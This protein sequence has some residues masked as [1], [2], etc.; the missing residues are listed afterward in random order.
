MSEPIPSPPSYPIIGHAGTGVYDPVAS[1]KSRR[2]LREKYGSIY[3]LNFFGREIIFCSSQE[4]VNEL[5]DESR[6][7]KEVAGGPLEE[8]RNGIHDGLF[9]A[10]GTEE[11]WGIAHRVLLPGFGPA[12]IQGMFLAMLDINAQLLL[13]WE[14]F[15]PDHVITPTEDFTRL[16]FDTIALSM[17]SHRFNSFYMEEM[18]PFCQ[19]MTRFLIESG[20]RNQ[21][22]SM[23][24]NL[25]RAENAQYEADIK[26]MAD[27]CDQRKHSREKR[28]KSLMVLVV[29]QNRKSHPTSKKDLLTLMLEGRD[30][31]TGRGM[32]EANIRN[33]L[34]TM[35]IA[36][37]ETT[38]GLLSYTLFHLLSNP[39]TYSKLQAEVDAIVGKD[40]LQ[41]AHVPKLEYTQAVL[42]ESIRLNPPAGMI[43]VS[44]V[45]D[46]VIA[47]K[48]AVKKGAMLAVDIAGLHR[49][50]AAWGDDVEEFKPERMMSPHFE[51]LPVIFLVCVPPDRHLRGFSFQPNCWKPFGNGS[52]G[53]IG[54][55]LAWQESVM[56][57]ATLFQHF[58]IKFDDPSYKLR[59]KQTLTTKP[60]GFQIRTIPRKD[61]P[62]IVGAGVVA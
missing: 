7:Q 34:I 50:P 46:T 48:Y 5:C 19:A 42:R 8:V 60:E 33:N 52:R 12:Q 22:P 57:L 56:M 13:K 62:P 36:G 3:R 18:P 28:G 11:N 43:S 26:F 16:A 27:V 4:I 6:F 40:A 41:L 38:S 9:T 51:A 2:Q 55:P 39:S 23:I 47:G 17:M 24:Q 58:D 31:K 53:C 37:H 15:G 45:E 29:V 25:M 20:V 61:A 10:F 49:D 1:A 21:R 54:R 59:V 35:L 14:R 30:P 44:P 32:S